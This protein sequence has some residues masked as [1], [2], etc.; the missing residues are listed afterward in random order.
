MIL[1]TLSRCLV[2]RKL[3]KIKLQAEPFD[4]KT[5]KEKKC[6]VVEHLNISEEESD[7]FVFTGEA[8]NTTY[9]PTDERINILFKDGT[10]KDI[11]KIDNALIHQ[12]LSGPVKKYYI[13]HYRF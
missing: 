11:S 5:I 3:F 4:E 1:S 8:I 7:Y 2:D 10:I 13:C 6:K 12:Q 9:D